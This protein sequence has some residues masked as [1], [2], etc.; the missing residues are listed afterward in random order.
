[1]LIQEGK[2][3]LI[4]AVLFDKEG[5]VVS[6]SGSSSAPRRAKRVDDHFEYTLTDVDANASYRYTMEAHDENKQLINT[7]KG[8]FGAEMPTGIE[9]AESQEPKAKSQKRIKDGQLIILREGKQYNAIGA[10]IK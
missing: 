1:M 6:T 10:E 9:T 4:G 7:D 2:E 3:M 5:H 8:S